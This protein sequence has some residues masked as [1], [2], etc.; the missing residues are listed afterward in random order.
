[1]DSRFTSR[2]FIA[3]VKTARANGEWEHLWRK[4][5]EEM[6]RGGG[7]GG[8]RRKKIDH[9]PWST[10]VNERVRE[11]N[12]GKGEGEGGRGRRRRRRRHSGLLLQAL[13]RGGGRLG[14]LEGV[15]FQTL[16]IDLFVD[17]SSSLHPLL[18]VVDHVLKLFQRFSTG[19]LLSLSLF[20]FLPPLL[21]P[22]TRLPLGGNRSFLPKHLSNN[23][24]SGKR[25]PCTFDPLT[26]DV[27]TPISI[28]PP[29]KG[30]ETHRT[31]GGK[32]KDRS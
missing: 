7:G 17:G 32:G 20:S 22:G 1:M 19:S 15:P 21:C 14:R 6:I 9:R 11:R 13:V 25:Y 29:P 5:T 24:A 30:G 18:V 23:R 26:I 16:R 12:I 8:R 2:I 4:R 28:L 27:S 3:S 31:E 10:P